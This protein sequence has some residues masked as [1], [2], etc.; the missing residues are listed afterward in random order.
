MQGLRNMGNWEIQGI[1]DIKNTSDR[2]RLTTFIFETRLKDLVLVYPCI[3]YGI[4]F[5]YDIRGIPYHRWIWYKGDTYPYP[6]N[7][8]IRLQIFSI[9]LQI[10]LGDILNH[11]L[12]FIDL[13]VLA[14]DNF[15]RLDSLFIFVENI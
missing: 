5:E 1:W 7:R 10:L 15:D 6:G 12:Y 2:F 11:F 8:Q 4:I 14:N 3:S 9:V 13:G